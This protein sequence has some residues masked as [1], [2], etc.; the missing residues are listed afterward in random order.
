MGWSK[1]KQ[2]EHPCRFST[3]STVHRCIILTCMGKI[4]I[5]IENIDK[6]TKSTRVQQYLFNIDISTFKYIGIQIYRYNYVR[7][8]ALRVC[9]LGWWR[10]ATARPV[11]LTI[12]VC[13]LEVFRIFPGNK[14]SVHGGDNAWNRRQEVPIMPRYQL[15]PVTC[16]SS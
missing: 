11:D 15:P 1:I 10:H 6:K 13:V 8:F 3:K 2:I 16:N 12:F 14:K 5:Y 9:R 7:F 4:Y